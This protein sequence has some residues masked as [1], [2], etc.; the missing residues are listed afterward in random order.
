[1][2]TPPSTPE[3]HYGPAD[4]WAPPST[5]GLPTYSAGG[6]PETGGEYR[7]AWAHE[8]ASHAHP[9]AA[10]G[11][12][13]RSTGG[14]WRIVLGIVLLFALLSSLAGQASQAASTSTDDPIATLT[15]V[16]LN[17][18]MLGLGVWL[19]VSGARRNAEKRRLRRSV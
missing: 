6:T 18:L 4:P 16:V 8:A 3:P 11:R 19:I 7:Q 12:R 14:T 13:R 9:A 2:T 1:M 10:G 15:V 17:F 5:G